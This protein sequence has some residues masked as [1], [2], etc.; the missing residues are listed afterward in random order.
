MQNGG[1]YII[2]ELFARPIARVQTASP[3]VR[4]RNADYRSI[5][6]IKFFENS[7]LELILDLSGWQ[8]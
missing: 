2:N 3:E 4:D 1:D 8:Q 5:K 7:P 6:R